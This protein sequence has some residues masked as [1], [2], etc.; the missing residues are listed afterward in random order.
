[1]FSLEDH[2]TA[3]LC[4]C[5]AVYYCC[6]CK[7]LTEPPPKKTGED[8]QLQHLRHLGRRLH[9]CP[10][11]GTGA[12]RGGDHHVSGRRRRSHDAVGFGCAGG[13]NPRANVSGGDDCTIGGS[14]YICVYIRA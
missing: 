13:C 12:D 1:M 14:R 10:Y 3:T 2:T 9:G 7:N 6:A 8:F 5:T 4:V 11:P